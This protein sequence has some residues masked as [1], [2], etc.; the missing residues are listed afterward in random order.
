MEFRGQKV[1]YYIN[2]KSGVY[3]CCVDAPKAFDMVHHDKLFDILI[4]HK[5][6][7]VALKSLLHMY[8]R[9]CMRTVW[10]TRFS[11]QFGTSYVIR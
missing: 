7:A 4:D 5:V 2:N 8:Q 6:P 11:K 3:S 9:K 10:K 1:F